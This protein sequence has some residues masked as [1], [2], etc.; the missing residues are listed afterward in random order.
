MR[1][2]TTLLAGCFVCDWKGINLRCFRERVHVL[3]L[4][5][6]R[7]FG[8][9]WP[10]NRIIRLNS[11]CNKHAKCCT[12]SDP[13]IFCSFDLAFSLLVFSFVLKRILQFW[14]KSIGFLWI[15]N[16]L[17]T[18]EVLEK[19]FFFLSKNKNRI[20]FQVA[21]TLAA[22]IKIK[23]LLLAAFKSNDCWFA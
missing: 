4:L 15:S 1:K 9:K 21:S 22:F 12:C 19:R 11:S 10:F 17:N 20:E 13:I 6:Y 16:V 5:N 3:L 2:F 7:L 14:M 8:T 23:A 18:F